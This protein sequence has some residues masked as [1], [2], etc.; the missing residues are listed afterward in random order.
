MT[1]KTRISFIP[2][3]GERALIVGQT[4]SGKTAFACFLLKRMIDS[5]IIIYDSK[6]DDKF[7]TLP[8]S[9]VAYDIEDVEFLKEDDQIDY[10]VFR[11]SVDILVK[12]DEMDKL[13]TY[14]YFNHQNIP[15]YIDEIYMF[16]SSGRAGSGLIS[17]LTRGRSK[18]I[19]TIMSTQRP[20]WLSMFSITESQKFF[21]FS[22]NRDSDRKKIEDFIPNYRSYRPTEKYGFHYFSVDNDVATRYSPVPLD[23]GIKS[24][25]VDDAIENLDAK[26]V[27]SRIWI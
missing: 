15:A 18:G 24:G 20:A 10:I 12:P 21:V 11:P 4:G 16:H 8:N 22:L 7:L 17:L 25:Y 9:R 5:P 19:T 6:F 26:K 2:E 13:L 3:R 1:K 14:H 23:K 27:Q